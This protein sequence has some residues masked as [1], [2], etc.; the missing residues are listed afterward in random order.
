MALKRHPPCQWAVSS[1]LFSEV[2][3][4]PVVYC[5]L[6]IVSRR[7]GREALCPPATPSARGCRHPA[8]DFG[9]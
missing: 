1:P 5:L 3:I 4:D 6:D 7:I 2:R 9:W 8:L